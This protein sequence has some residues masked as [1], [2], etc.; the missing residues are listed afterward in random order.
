MIIDYNPTDDLIMLSDADLDVKDVGIQSLFK[1]Q[2]RPDEY[3]VIPHYSAF[4]ILT[5]EFPDA[6]WTD[7][8][9]T[10]RAGMGKWR[11]ECRS[12]FNNM[13]LRGDDNYFAFQRRTSNMLHLAGAGFINDDTGLGKTRTLISTVS[14]A[15]GPHI[16]VCPAIA[17]TVWA[18]EIAKV[19]PSFD[20][21]VIDGD[22]TAR[23]KLL[24]SDNIYKHDF[25]I[26]NYELLKKHVS[27]PSWTQK[28]PGDPVEKELDA[29]Q[30]GAVIV[31][32]GHRIKNPEAITTRCCWRLRDRSE[33]AYVA[34]AT[35]ITQT[36]Y[37]LWSQL[38]FIHPE[39]W[40]SRSKFRDRYLQFC[41]MPHGGIEVIGWKAGMHDEFEQVMSWRTSK[42]SYNDRDVQHELKDMPAEGP[43][44]IIELPL[45]PDQR[46]LYKQMVDQM[47]LD[48]S[49]MDK[50]EFH[51][52]AS[53]VEK[54]VRLRQVACGIPIIKNDG[55][56]IGLQGPS[57]KLSA[58]KN[59]V[60]DVDGPVVIF[61]QHSKVA[62]MI[63]RAL[64][65]AE[66]IYGPT[67][68]A[69]R[70]AFIDKFQQGEIPYLVCTSGAASTAITLTNAHMLIIAQESTSLLEMVQ[71]RG[72]VRRI[73][74]TIPVPVYVLRSKGTVEIALADGNS[75]K[76]GFLD[77][78]LSSPNRYRSLLMGELE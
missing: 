65:G 55:E 52:A 72:R 37:D 75:E 3:K 14:D 21:L 56:I 38:R 15:P 41:E 20:V 24:T 42:R 44:Q 26:I 19:D 13:S 18:R 69:M 40:L 54:W 4:L 30:W 8:A 1:V 34:T 39:E 74:S 43:T 66:M 61:A 58:V 68:N 63:N 11:N 70:T 57:N 9:K 77:E 62:A 23:R 5:K 53:D 31:D 28:Y 12:R 76:A 16:I 50:E 71:A 27:Y 51:I 36:P 59:I 45:L 29:I 47:I 35:P 49:I 46:A 22:A 6:T 2:K 78:Y 17:K 32:E 60:E 25:V 48:L 10:A 64:P 33:R 7:A 67:P 73:G